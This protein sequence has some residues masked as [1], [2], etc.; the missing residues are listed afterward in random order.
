MQTLRQ[1]DNV[2]VNINFGAKNFAQKK[3]E[4][5]GEMLQKHCL[6]VCTTLFYSL[7][8]PKTDPFCIKYY[9]LLKQNNATKN[10]HFS[11]TEDT[12]LRKLNISF[13]NE[14]FWKLWP[15]ATKMKKILQKL[16]LLQ[17]FRFY[18]WRTYNEKNNTFKTN[19]HFFSKLTTKIL[20]KPTVIFPKIDN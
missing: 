18:Q 12:S 7:I 16:V 14:H 20:L 4:I 11:K 8:C 17:D 13:K 19:C 9:F 10:W 1:S 2:S 3:C 15:F 5:L 6:K